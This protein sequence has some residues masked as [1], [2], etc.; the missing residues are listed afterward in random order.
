MRAGF[1][2]AMILLSAGCGRLDFDVRPQLDAATQLDVAT[3]SRGDATGVPWVLEQHNSNS[4]VAASSTLSATVAATTAGDLIV[5]AVQVAAPGG[6]ASIDDNAGTAYQRIA[7]SSAQAMANGGMLEIWYAPTA[8]AGATTITVTANMTARAIVVWEFR[9]S[10]VATVDTATE[11]SNQPQAANPVGPAITT[12]SSGELVI[13]AVVVDSQQI[14]GIAAGNAFTNDETANA[15]GWAHLTDSSAP[16]GTYQAK[17]NTNVS[18]TYCASAA[19][20]VVQ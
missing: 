17:W 11:V 4:T 10:R 20:F 14:T 12:G 5:A 6:V 3:D 9:T 15:N 18:D 16:A 13:S 2:I 19:A 8:N 1:A 7:G